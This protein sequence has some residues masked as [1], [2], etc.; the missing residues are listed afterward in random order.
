VSGA[1]GVEVG[2][3]LP[4]VDAEVLTTVDG[5]FIRLEADDAPSLR[6]ALNSFLRWAQMA[7]EVSS[8]AAAPKK[9]D[10]E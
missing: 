10:N 4:K 3:G 2:G 8:G 6:A 7:A 9:D 5:V 1:L